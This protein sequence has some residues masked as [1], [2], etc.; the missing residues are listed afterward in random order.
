MDKLKI[1]ACSGLGDTATKDAYKWWSD[2]TNT[3]TNTQA[4]NAL[5]VKINLLRAQILHLQQS[6]EERTEALNAL[7]LYAVCLYF[8]RQ[9]DSN[10]K[11]LE[12]IGKAIG[13]VYEEGAFANASLNL[14]NAEEIYNQI[15]ARVSEVAETGTTTPSATFEEWWQKHIVKHN[16]YGLNKTERER[17]QAA[18]KTVQGI[19]KADDSWKE[20][21]DISEYLTNASEYFLYLYFTDKQLRKLPK[22]FSKKAAEQGVTYDYCKD[23]FVGVYG[24]EEDMQDVIRTGIIGYFNHTPEEVCDKIAKG[25]KVEP[26]NGI[27]LV[28]TVADIIAVITAVL[29]FIG[30]LITLLVQYAAKVKEAEYAAIDQAAIDA[31]C[32]A[33]EDYEGLSLD[34]LKSSS[35]WIPL[36]AIGLG[37]LILLKN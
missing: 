9:Y 13:T 7:M 16:Q 32:P 4:I 17:L 33:P 11:S 12:R 25:E 5:L 8:V 24:T 36:A 26:A 10:Y 14:D 30:G 21:K 6:H 37:A 20:D 23:V 3:I 18:V 1:Y 2:D 19:G 22:V 35:S 15:I 28:W 27:G 34:G 29:S 31:S